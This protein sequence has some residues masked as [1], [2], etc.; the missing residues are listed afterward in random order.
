MRAAYDFGECFNSA[1]DDNGKLACM[2][3]LMG[4][5]GPYQTDPIF[6]DA[7]TAELMLHYPEALAFLYEMQGQG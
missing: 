2:M 1:T 4:I 6:G 3:G 7:F 5:Y